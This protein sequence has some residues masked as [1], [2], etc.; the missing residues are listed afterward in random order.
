MSIFD[1]FACLIVGTEKHS[2]S[3][4]ISSNDA[5]IT[6]INRLNCADANDK[7]LG[8]QPSSTSANDM[9]VPSSSSFDPK[10]GGKDVNAQI[11]E[12][13]AD[14]FESMFSKL[15]HIKGFESYSLHS[16]I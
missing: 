11:T 13:E 16:L 3:H 14:K 12:H 8:H 2:S 5:L 10:P 15:T 7:D 4:K 1:T 6:Q 9:A